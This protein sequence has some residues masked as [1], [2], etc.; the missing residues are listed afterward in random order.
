MVMGGA[1]NT[2]ESQIL[3]AI[4]PVPVQIE[5]ADFNKDGFLDVAIT[6]LGTSGQYMQSLYVLLGTGAGGFVSPFT[7]VTSTGSTSPHF[8][9]GDFNGDTWPDLAILREGSSIR[10][11]FNAQAVSGVA[12]TVPSVDVAIGPNAKRIAAAD[13]D[14]DGKDDCAVAT[15]TTTTSGSIAIYVSDG[16]GGAVA[17]A[18]AASVNGAPTCIAAGLVD[19]DGH[20]DVAVGV[21]T[22]SG[23]GAGVMFGNGSGA[24]AE[25]IAV[26]LWGEAREVALGDLNGDGL[27]DLVLVEPSQNHLAS[28]LVDEKSVFMRGDANGDSETDISDCVSLLG[29]LFAARQTDCVEALDANDDFQVNIADPVYLLTYL[30]AEGPEPPLPFPD[31]GMD[32]KAETLGCDR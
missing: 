5:K 18:G 2:F 11:A 28:V 32:P 24:L 22:A 8:A 15:E 1:S 14:G 13:F 9:V 17:V 19:R 23:Y 7:V 16:I 12:F 20:V 31:G 25:P 29:Y 30:F 21:R 10:F 3:T 6:S 4:G 27:Q 26:D